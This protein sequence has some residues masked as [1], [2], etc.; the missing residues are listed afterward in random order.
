MS[1]LKVSTIGSTVSKWGEGPVWWQGS[2]LYVDIENHKIISL[3]PE[4]GAEQSWD[5]GERVGTVVPTE[6]ADFIYAGDTGF[7]RFNPK[8]GEKTALIDPE[9][10]MHATNRFNDGKCDPAGRF[11]AGSISLVKNPGTAHLYCLETDGSLSKKVEDVTNSNGICWS[12]DAS[13]MYYIDTAT[14]AIAVFNYDQASGEI[15]NR[16]QLVS[17][18]EKGYK[19][20]PDGMTIDAA[21]NLWVAFCHGG[22]VVCFDGKSGDV[23]TEV[24]IPCVETTACAFGGEN[25]DRLFVT[26]GIHKSLV[27]EDAGRVF[28]IDGLGVQGV[29]AFAYQGA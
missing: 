23:I 6:G 25:L 22:C 20:S 28:V 8:T 5:V 29:K 3:D 7:V 1:E 16:Q 9:P 10:H 18:S 11:W 15:N 4:T 27:E 26:T 12:L 14:K 13:R 21:G 2:L 24:K 19:D 17:T